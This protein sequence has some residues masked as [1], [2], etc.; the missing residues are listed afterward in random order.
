MVVTAWSFQ[1]QHTQHRPQ[2]QWHSQNQL[3]LKTWPVCQC[4]PLNLTKVDKTRCLYEFCCTNHQWMS[5]YI[6]RCDSDK[7]HGAC[8]SQWE[9]RYWNAIRFTFDYRELLDQQNLS[10]LPR[11]RD[12][13][14]VISSLKI[15]FRAEALVLDWALYSRQFITRSLR[16]QAPRVKPKQV[17]RGGGKAEAM[18]GSHILCDVPALSKE[19][20]NFSL[21][22]RLAPSLK[23]L[24]ELCPTLNTC[25]LVNTQTHISS[26]E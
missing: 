23:I 16:W 9:R 18:E 14:E 21:S 10:S 8:H 26:Q 1:V 15:F 11:I 25:H 22:P 17:P 7:S 20:I 5:L 3:K 24:T 6:Y 13:M 2:L 19:N 4:H 12:W